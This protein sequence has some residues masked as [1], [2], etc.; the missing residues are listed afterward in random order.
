MPEIVVASFNAHWG[1]G[2]FGGSRSESFDVAAAVRSFG[3]DVVVIAEAWRPHD[4]ECVLDVLAGEGWN[5]EERRFATLR[6]LPKPEVEDPGDGW[7]SLAVLSRHPV[8]ARR[9]IPLARVF[10]DP[11]RRRAAIAVTLDVEG[12]AVDVI[13]VHVSSKLWY[14]GPLIQLGSLRRRLQGDGRPEIVAGDFN[15][16]GPVVGRLLPGR[17]RGAGAHVPGAPAAQ[18]DRPRARG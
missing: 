8:S 12:V 1:V 6:L 10:H 14:A 3:A 11:V 13:A 16:W 9:D 5:V 17:R 4:G 15:L 2:R 18:P 7:W